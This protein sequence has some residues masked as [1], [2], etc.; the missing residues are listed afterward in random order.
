MQVQELLSAYYDGELP[1]ESRQAVAD[2]VAQCTACAG[3][4]ARYE[5]L[6]QLSAQLP[7]PESSSDWAELERHLNAEVRQSRFSWREWLAA[8]AGR[9]AIAAVLLVAVGMIVFVQRYRGE[10]PG[11]HLTANFDRYLED[12]ATSPDAAQNLLLVSYRGQQADFP[13]ATQLVGY[14][15]AAQNPPAGYTVVAVY[16]LDMPCCRCPQVVL[17]RP[18]GSRLAVFEHEIDQP[19]WFGDRPAIRANC[20]G[21]PARIVEAEDRLLA[22]TWRSTKRDLTIVGA[23]DIQEITKIVGHFEGIDTDQS[24]RVF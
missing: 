22:A 2:H 4:L 21:K 7:S 10:S 13:H 6:T 11:G 8:P 9:V 1:R 19:V 5:Q 12:F 15:P 20:C 23:R 14:T 18:D 17:K 24:D 16:V 3:A